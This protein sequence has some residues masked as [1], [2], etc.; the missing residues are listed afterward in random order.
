[1]E[2]TIHFH[3]KAPK[4]GG[5]L[6]CGEVGVHYVHD[7]VHHHQLVH[8]RFLFLPKFQQNTHIEQK[9]YQA[10][11]N[12]KIHETEFQLFINNLRILDNNM[13]LAE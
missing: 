2:V 10:K 1:M 8:Y 6:K 3:F 12:S 9:S 4:V 11:W 5:L 13:Y 7:A